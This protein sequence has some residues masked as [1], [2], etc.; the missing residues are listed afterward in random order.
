MD[1]HIIKHALSEHEDKKYDEIRFGVR[2]VSSIPEAAL[3]KRF[4]IQI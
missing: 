3:K 2:V 4:V 1:S